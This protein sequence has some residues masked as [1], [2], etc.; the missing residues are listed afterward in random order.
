MELEFGSRLTQFKIYFLV[1]VVS[2][3]AVVYSLT[4]FMK[5]KCVL[6]FEVHG[7]SFN[8]N[9]YF[10]HLVYPSSSSVLYLSEFNVPSYY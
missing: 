7:F 9:Y 6:G 1:A 8:L 4:F 10:N 5:L 2:F 3:T